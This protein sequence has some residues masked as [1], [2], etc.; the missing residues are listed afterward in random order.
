MSQES[1]PVIVPALALVVFL[2]LGILCTFYPQYVQRYT[3]SERASKLSPAMRL[4]FLRSHVESA[5]YIWE[6]RIAGI[7]CLASAALVIYALV[8]WPPKVFK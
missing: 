5:V 1:T 4:R 8:E 3:L 2:A 6:L 7:L